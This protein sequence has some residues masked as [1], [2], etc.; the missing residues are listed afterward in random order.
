MFILI[1]VFLFAIFAC[2]FVLYLP[3]LAQIGDYKVDSR[4]KSFK[5]KT[6]ETN[7]QFGGYIP[8]DELKQLNEANRQTSKINQLK[9][10]KKYSSFKTI[11]EDFNK[12]KVTTDDIP[13]KFK[14]TDSNDYN[15][16]DNKNI[17]RRKKKIQSLEDATNPSTFDYDI[18]EFNND[19]DE[20]QI[21]N[22]YQ[23]RVSN[24]D[25]YLD[26]IA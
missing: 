21:Q 16:N 2:L 15:I 13:L 11:K 23:Q 1:V 10:L 19:S 9:G 7:H 4:K 25:D 20:E 12:I 26:N 17:R 22:E 24:K 18:D 3:K 14:L 8:P 5:S 6:Q